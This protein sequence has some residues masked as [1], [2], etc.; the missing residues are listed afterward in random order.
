[1]LK[2]EEVGTP[3]NIDSLENLLKREYE[4]ELIG[5]EASSRAE[6][7]RAKKDP[8]SPKF[9]HEL[10]LKMTRKKMEYVPKEQL[11]DY[12]KTIQEKVV[13]QEN[14][15]TED[16][17]GQLLSKEFQS[18]RALKRI[19]YE[20]ECMSSGMDKESPKLQT[21][22]DLKKRA[23]AKKLIETIPILHFFPIGISF[24]RNLMHL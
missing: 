9:K 24:N 5:Y 18:E 3:D 22:V 12:R 15:S 19:S 7:I 23:V 20:E 10:D 6:M 1:M 14:I 8:E 2:G 17:A 4:L 13:C 16:I 11:D 21:T